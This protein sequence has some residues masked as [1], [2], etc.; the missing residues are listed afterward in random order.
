[1]GTPT[2]LA[3]LPTATPMAV[4]SPESTMAMAWSPESAPLVTE[5]CTPMPPLCT[6]TPLS[7][8]CTMEPTCKSE[9]EADA[10]AY[11]VH[12]VA[13]GLPVHNA[14]ATGHPHNVGVVTGVSHG[15]YAHA[16]AP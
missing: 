13:A 14:Y 16:Y 11:T 7:L 2:P 10:E 9:A 12:Q 1:M 4:S 3:R 6:P 5:L 8:P 15:V